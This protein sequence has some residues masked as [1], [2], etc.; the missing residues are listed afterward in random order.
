MLDILILQ[1]DIQ[2]ELKKLK[3]IAVKL[4]YDE[5]EFLV[6]EKYF[7]KIE[8]KNNIWFQKFRAV[9]TKVYY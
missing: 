9:K 2:K 3:K 5:I 4:N 7:N 1:K 6:Q 8:V